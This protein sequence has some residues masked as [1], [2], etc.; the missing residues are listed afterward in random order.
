MRYAVLRNLPDKGQ[1]AQKSGYVQ[2]DAV[3]RI[4]HVSYR[5]RPQVAKESSEKMR[6]AQGRRGRQH[7]F[8]DAI[9][10]AKSEFGS[11]NSAS[12]ER[13]YNGKPDT[14]N[15][16]PAGQPENQKTGEQGNLRT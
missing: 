1:E 13:H 16:K 8:G 5:K 10:T 3:P 14:R 2:V 9:S 12:G 6:H 15:A 7:H 4:R 11:P